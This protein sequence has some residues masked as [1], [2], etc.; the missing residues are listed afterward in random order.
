MNARW[1]STTGWAFVAAYLVLAAFRFHHALTCSGWVCDLAALPAVVP[2]GFPLA[3]LTDWV[4]AFFP[5]PGHAPTFHLRNWYFILPTVS[6]N[7]ILYYWLG[8]YAER[9]VGRRLRRRS[10]I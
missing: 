10:R 9:L 1:R 3:W 5:I 2:L 7:A 8:R 4:H 6:A